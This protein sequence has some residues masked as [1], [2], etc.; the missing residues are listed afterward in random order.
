MPR[1]T[2]ETRRPVFPRFT[3]RTAGLLGIVGHGSAV[4]D[5][6]AQVMDHPAGGVRFAGSTLVR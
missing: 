3:Y 4:R 2:R 5:L 1:H 6:L